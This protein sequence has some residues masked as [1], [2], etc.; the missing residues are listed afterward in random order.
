MDIKNFN[1]VELSDSECQSTN[2][3]S[4]LSYAIGYI[5]GVI[6]NTAETHIE[7]LVETSKT[8]FGFLPK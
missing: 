5:A 3:G 6:V 8:P 1:V 2:G 4:W 7:T